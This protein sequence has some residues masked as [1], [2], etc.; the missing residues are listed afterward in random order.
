[1][2]DTRRLTAK[3]IDEI[4]L[5]RIMGHIGRMNEQQLKINVIKSYL[6][7]ADILSDTLPKLA[8]IILNEQSSSDK[9]ELVMRILNTNSTSRDVIVLTNL[10][11]EKMT[12]Q[13]QI[14]EATAHLSNSSDTTDEQLIQWNEAI[15]ITDYDFLTMIPTFLETIG[16]NSQFYNEIV[17]VF[18]D[19]KDDVDS[20]KTQLRFY[21]DQTRI[22]LAD[23]NDEDVDIVMNQLGMMLLDTPIGM[24]PNNQR[25]SNLLSLEFVQ[26]DID[27][28][29]ILTKNTP[30]ADIKL[31]RISEY[32]R[33]KENINIPQWIIQLL[34]GEVLVFKNMRADYDK[35]YDLLN[36]NSEI[37]NGTIVRNIARLIDN[38]SIEN[39]ELIMSEVGFVDPDPRNFYE[40]IRQTANKLRR[41]ITPGMTE[42]VRDLNAIDSMINYLNVAEANNPNNLT[43][44]TMLDMLAS[45]KD[46][47]SI[48]FDTN[49]QSVRGILQN[50]EIVNNDIE[51]FINDYIIN[52]PRKLTQEE[53][54]SILNAVPAPIGDVDITT[55]IWHSM[56][57]KLSKQLE[58]YKITPKA[59]PQLREKIKRQAF[60]ARQTPN[61]M[62]GAQAAAAMGATVTQ[63]TLNTFHK[64]GSAT[65]VTS[66]IERT[67]ELLNVKKDPKSASNTIFF[68]SKIPFDMAKNMLL[69]REPVSDSDISKIGWSFSEVLNKRQVIVGITVDMLLLSDP[70][71]DTYSNLMNDTPWWYSI[72]N[73]IYNTETPRSNWFLRLKLNPLI[74]Y[75]Y[76]VTVQDVVEAITTGTWKEKSACRNVHGINLVWTPDGMGVD[77]DGVS[78]PVIDIFPDEEI[79]EPVMNEVV[80]SGENNAYMFLSKIVSPS[81]KCIKVKGVEG[82]NE[83]FPNTLPVWNAVERTEKIRGR[84]WLITIKQRESVFHGIYNIHVAR[85]CRAVGITIIDISDDYLS[86]QV[87]IPNDLVNDP[88]KIVN[89]AISKD[90]DEA[91]DYQEEKLRQKQIPSRRPD[92]KIAKAAF[93]NYLET[94]GSNLKKI[95]TL[96][97]V[98]H[99]R[100]YSNVPF[101]DFHVFGIESARNRLLSEVFK[102]FAQAGDLP[103]NLRHI[104]LLSDFMSSQGYLV[105][106]TF[107]GMAA[108]PTGF[109]TKTG[110]EKAMDVVSEASLLAESEIIGG[111]DI[112]GSV[113]SSI[114]VGQRAKMGTGSIEITMDRTALRKYIEEAKSEVYDEKTFENVVK[115]TKSRAVENQLVP[116][117][118][119]DYEGEEDEFGDI[120]PSSTASGRYG[121]YSD[122]KVAPSPISTPSRLIGSQ[123]GIMVSP[124]Q[125]LVAEQGGSISC[126]V[127]PPVSVSVSPGH[128]IGSTQRSTGVSITSLLA[129]V[130][131]SQSPLGQ[132]DSTQPCT[133]N[134]RAS[135]SNVTNP[136]SILNTAHPVIAGTMS[137][138]MPP[139]PPDPN[140]ATRTAPVPQANM[141]TF[142]QLLQ[143]FG[144]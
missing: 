69:S 88:S 18:N 95:L 142:D 19:N 87:E 57:F 4:V 130:T 74:M 144:Q 76:R 80:M 70:E 137:N 9:L 139:V 108:Q 120:D 101:E 121:S 131:S 98:D 68:E 26:Q 37:S 51:A 90:I 32:L 82:I 105:S 75:K 41:Q 45:F 135:I 85:L 31:G 78:I 107:G 59:I 1:M 24:I 44:S 3:E 84:T 6:V 7:K 116:D 11:S 20:L 125:R 14:I 73:A 114:F 110:Y 128:G 8:N 36:F 93:H 72:F 65:N 143:P 43:T 55:S 97:D 134:L 100:T 117:S 39:V 12:P 22:Q 35:L 136:G 115:S 23:V 25:I 5:P 27:L 62:V 94:V 28:S 109:L 38:G 119:I 21:F 102:V 124:E 118:N 140:V 29:N 58:V 48:D 66:G 40:N 113:T 63:M 67:G 99:T 81:F 111:S 138:T 13:Q 132:C 92:T 71:I 104:M 122:S 77:L 10:L 133:D 106:L 126:T 2:A 53:I 89:Q 64:A 15:T 34:E 30:S 33:N 127:Q 103:I 86:L 61:T 17:Q 60:A 112:E 50:Q 42:R 123:P 91:T 54:V 47:T 52:I 16:Q 96:P 129:A 141:V 49:I 56:L 46:E 83:V 79:I